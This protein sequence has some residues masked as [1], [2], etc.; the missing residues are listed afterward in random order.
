MRD[1]LEDQERMRMFTHY[2]GKAGALE[3]AAA[4][5]RE[6]SG[7]CFA[8]GKDAAADFWREAAKILEDRAKSERRTQNQYHPDESKRTP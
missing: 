4:D 1:E 8:A 7:K 5:F 3:A 6:R 2:A